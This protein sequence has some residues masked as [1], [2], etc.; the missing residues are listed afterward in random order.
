MTRG[1]A[2][3]RGI[4]PCNQKVGG[5]P[6]WRL[7]RAGEA[8]GWDGRGGWAGRAGGRGGQAGRAG[9]AAAGGWGGRAGRDGWAGRAG[10]QAVL[11]GGAVQSA[12]S[13]PSPAPPSPTHT[14]VRH[15]KQ[16]LLHAAECSDVVRPHISQIC[17]SN[18][19]RLFCGKE[20]HRGL[21]S[22]MRSRRQTCTARPTRWDRIGGRAAVLGA[23]RG[24]K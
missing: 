9:A 16:A 5:G 12:Y 23:G 19:T 10:A 18:A 3:G 8:G 15:D 13:S 21:T 14:C 1:R 11:A 22:G 24:D 6:C 20:G 7:G 2:R 4:G 17:E